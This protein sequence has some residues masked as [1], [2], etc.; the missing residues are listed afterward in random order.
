M[1][2]RLL[3][4]SLLLKQLLYVFSTDLMLLLMFLCYIFIK[5]SVVYHFICTMIFYNCSNLLGSF[6]VLQTVIIEQESSL[7]VVLTKDILSTSKQ[8]S[9]IV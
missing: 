6:S 2:Y 8:Q 3:T 1:V 4:I 5:A 7:Q 9:V